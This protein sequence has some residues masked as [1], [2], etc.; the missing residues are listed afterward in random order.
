MEIRAGDEADHIARLGDDQTALLA[1]HPLARERITNGL[2]H[3]HEAAVH[4]RGIVQHVFKQ[5]FLN[6]YIS[7]AAVEMGGVRHG[8]HIAVLT[9]RQGHLIAAQG[10]V[11]RTLTD[12]THAPGVM[13]GHVFE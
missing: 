3:P 1:V 9:L 8:R 4:I 11:F 5:T 6:Q 10:E 13:H 7:P 12:Q 2:L